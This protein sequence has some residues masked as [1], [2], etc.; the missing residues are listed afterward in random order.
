M[1]SVFLS[2]WAICLD[3]SMYIWYSRWTC[4]GWIICPQKPHPFGNECHTACCAL[5]GIL[6]IVELAEGNAHPRQAGTLEF[7]DI[8]RKTV[9]LLLSMMKS[10]FPTGMYVIIDSGFCV[11]KGLI[12]LKKNGVFAC[13]VIKKRSYWPYMV[14]GK[15]MGDHSGEVGE[16]DA[17][18]GTVDD[19]IYSLWGM[20]EPK[21]VMRIMATGGRLLVDDTYKETVR[22]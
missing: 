7:E 18:Q 19:V 5:S 9:G 8:G 16:T 3:E 14:P 4:P 11:L 20:K 13:A 22:R 10:Y 21:Y 1:T 15:E 2:S 17:I 12:Q 6:F